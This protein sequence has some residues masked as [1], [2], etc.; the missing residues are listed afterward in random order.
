MH[1]RNGKY[2]LYKFTLD[3]LKRKATRSKATAPELVLMTSCLYQVALTNLVQ[4]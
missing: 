2:L 4:Q 1:I 3:E